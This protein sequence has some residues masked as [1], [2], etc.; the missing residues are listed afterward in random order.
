MAESGGTVGELG[1]FRVVGGVGRTGEEARW[2]L[3]Y[4]SGKVMGAQSGALGPPGT[5]CILAPQKPEEGSQAPHPITLPP[6]IIDRESWTEKFIHR[7]TLFWS[8]SGKRL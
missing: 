6:G 7:L 5:L 3:W 4:E 1:K 8:P 2:E